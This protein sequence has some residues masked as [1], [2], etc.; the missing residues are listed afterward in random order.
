[1]HN[2]RQEW[3][4]LL[5]TLDE[6]PDNIRDMAFDGYLQISKFRSIYWA[7]LLRVLNKDHHT[8]SLQRQ[9]QRKR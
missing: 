7:L 9:Q 8:W 6:N 1:M 5:Q 4:Q 2:Y 3:Q